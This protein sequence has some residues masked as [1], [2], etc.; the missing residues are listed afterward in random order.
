MGHWPDEDM[1]MVEHRKREK[2]ERE[3]D[4]AEAEDRHVDRYMETKIYSETGRER[5][6]FDNTA[7]GWMDERMQPK[8]PPDTRNENVSTTAQINYGANYVR[9][10]RLQVTCCD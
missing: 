8:T 2:Y 10:S 7:M 9:D 5:Q 3:R 4:G 6:T 1:C